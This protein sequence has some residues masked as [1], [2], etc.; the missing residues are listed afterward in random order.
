MCFPNEF[1]TSQSVCCTIFVMHLWNKKSNALY[2]RRPHWLHVGLWLLP[3]IPQRTM[4][5]KVYL[6]KTINSN[7][8]SG[9]FS[10]ALEHVMS[11]HVR[12]CPL[13]QCERLVCPQTLAY[14]HIQWTES[15]ISIHLKSCLWARLQ[16][17]GREFMEIMEE[18]WGWHATKKVPSRIWGRIAITWSALYPTGNHFKVEGL[19]ICHSTT[20]CKL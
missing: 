11:C 12:T 5:L 20:K 15:N 7:W 6:K 4:S 8:F 19:F 13:V 1:S 16:R 3:Q 9:H 17:V 14:S 2:W 10:R 18:R